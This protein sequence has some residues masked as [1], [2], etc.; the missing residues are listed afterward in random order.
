MQHGGLAGVRWTPPPTCRRPTRAPLVCCLAR[1]YKPSTGER[2]GLPNMDT[3]S[4][5]PGALICALQERSALLWTLSP[6]KSRPSCFIIKICT[7]I[8]HS[9]KFCFIMCTL[10]VVS[11]KIS[12]CMC[13]AKCK[14]PKF[15]P[16]FAPQCFILYFCNLNAVWQRLHYICILNFVSDLSL[17]VVHQPVYKICIL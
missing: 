7:Y 14:W 2:T 17:N 15:E 11:C 16:R 9:N 10:D 8:L 5:L 4:G 3:A 1:R 12:K 6:P 13:T